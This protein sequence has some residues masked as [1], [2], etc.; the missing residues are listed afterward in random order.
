[1]VH[2]NNDYK[3]LINISPKYYV[4]FLS[5][6]F[7]KRPHLHNNN[8]GPLCSAIFCDAAMT[9]P[10]QDITDHHSDVDCTVRPASKFSSFLWEF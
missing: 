1:M 9:E 6:L 10:L 3:Y 4:Q 8:S 7:G 2:I 5:D